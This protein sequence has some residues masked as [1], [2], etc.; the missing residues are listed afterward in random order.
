MSKNKQIGVKILQQI[1]ARGRHL[2]DHGLNAAEQQAP[3]KA[4]QGDQ[5]AKITR[6]KAI[7]TRPPVMPAIH[8][9]VPTTTI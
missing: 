2:R 6:P 1:D 8:N 9:L 3:A 4:R 7:Q 5:R